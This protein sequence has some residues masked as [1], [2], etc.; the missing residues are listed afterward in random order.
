VA[1]FEQFTAPMKEMMRCAAGAGKGNVVCSANPRLVNGKPSKNPRYLQ[2]RPD[3]TN[4]M[5]KYV[6]EMGMR[7]FR[8][9]PADKPLLMPVEAILVGRRNN[10]E[11][12]A[13]HVRGLAVY[14]P[15]HYQD[16]PEL[17]MDFIC[18]LTGKS[19]STTGAG[20]E[21]AASAAYPRTACAVFQTQW[22]D[23]VVSACSAMV[24]PACLLFPQAG[25][26]AGRQDE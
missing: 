1:E 8:A 24:P 22:N 5:S 7:F 17:F 11:D 23:G 26:R 10:P 12:K 4:P 21:G 19:P 9:I 25:A 6:L 18:S 2:I 13:A 15:I 14:S 20:S 3:L 16:L